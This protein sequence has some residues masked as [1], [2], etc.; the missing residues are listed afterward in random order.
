MYVNA[1]VCTCMYVNACVYEGMYVYVC[2]LC[3]NMCESTEVN[4]MYELHLTIF[5]TEPL[6]DL[7]LS[8]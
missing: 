6:I 8:R 3:M 5:G 4:F 7:E 1:C 2:V